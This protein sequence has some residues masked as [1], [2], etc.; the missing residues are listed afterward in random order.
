MIKTGGCSIHSRAF[1]RRNGSASSALIRGEPELREQ[2]LF[3]PQLFDVVAQ[4]RLKLEAIGGRAGGPS[5]VHLLARS[6]TS[7]TTLEGAPSNAVFVG[8][9]F[10]FHR[11]VIPRKF[12]PVFFIAV[13]NERGLFSTNF[14]SLMGYR[15]A[16]RVSKEFA[17]G[18]NVLPGGRKQVKASRLARRKVAVQRPSAVDFSGTGGSF[19]PK[20][21]C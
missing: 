9:V 18:K 3:G 17:I 19:S 4:L 6:L 21:E 7:T 2:K 14:D 20:N 1:P 13:V 12:E 15:I 11:S 5:K 8:W 10:C 16:V